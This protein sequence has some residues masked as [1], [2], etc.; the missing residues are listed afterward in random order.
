MIVAEEYRELLVFTQTDHAR[1]AGELLSLWKGHDVP[2]HPRRADL[3]F[4]VREHDNGWRE[5]DAAPSCDRETGKPHDFLTLPEG[6]RREIWRRGTARFED[7]RPYPAL[8]ITLHAQNLIDHR[9][10]DESWQELLTELSERRQRLQETVA[11]DGDEAEQDYRLVDL[12]DLVSLTVCNRWTDPFERHGLRGRF[13]PEIN[14]VYLHPF[15]LAG[16]TTF[17][18][19]VRRIP[20]R[21]YEGDAD[22]GGELAAARW[23][24]LK[25]RVAPWAGAEV[26]E[27]AATEP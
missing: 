7:K 14:A 6:E 27:G 11:L 25:V 12:T 2:D 16:A 8:L 10:D 1:F 5:A 17:D 21:R 9:C 18:I 4:A 19:P 26:L 3:I 22:L 20:Q 24:E 13:D 23:Q 15:P